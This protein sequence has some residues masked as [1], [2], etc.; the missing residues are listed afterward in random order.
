MVSASPLIILGRSG[1]LWLLQLVGDPVLVPRTVA[2]E[3]EQ[4]GSDDP[5]VRALAELSWLEIVDTGPIAAAVA[6]CT[7]GRGE[8]A[9]LTWALAH[10]G[11]VAVLDDLPGRRC[12]A[13]L[14]I[15]TRGTLD[16]T[17]IARQRGVVARARPLVETVRQAGLY[18]SDRLRRG[19]G[20]GR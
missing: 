6:G 19:A 12:A 1:L 17:L 10:P 13:S 20:R 18:L 5:T 4:F 14:G 3:V 7:L 11:A 9:V 2:D 16:L 15:T 8:S